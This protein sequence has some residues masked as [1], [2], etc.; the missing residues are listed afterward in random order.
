MTGSDPRM[1]AAPPEAVSFQ[2]FDRVII[3][4]RQQRKQDAG[5]LARA[6]IRGLVPADGLVILAHVLMLASALA[7]LTAL[8]IHHDGQHAVVMGA[9]WLAAAIS[10]IAGFAFSAICGAMLFHLLDDP[11]KVVQI[12][13]ICSICNQASMVWSLRKNINWPEL[14]TYLMGGIIGV[15]AGVWILLHAD[16]RIYTHGMGVVLLGYALVMLFRKPAI[17]RKQP[18]AMDFMVGL[19]GGVTGGAAGFP[20]ASMSVWCGMKGWDRARQRATVQP[21]ILVMQ[22][23]ALALIAL[24]KTPAGTGGGFDLTGLMFVPASLVGTALGMAIYRR[25]SDGQFGHVV[26]G[27]MIVSGVS[28]ML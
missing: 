23:V 5:S 3:T 4:G 12:M 17:M 16:R 6:M 10:S 27:L 9:I 14:R 28:F 1:P 25:L 21:F 8:I 19:L 7:V 2:T 22:V 26:N 18:V 11:V 15:S 13:I 20:S 24:V